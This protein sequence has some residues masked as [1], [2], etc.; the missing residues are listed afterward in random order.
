MATG[1]RSPITVVSARP[2]GASSVAAAVAAVLSRFGRTLLVDLNLDRPEQ[3]ALLDLDESPNVFHLAY[4]S[5][6]GPA[7]PAELEDHLQ[8]RDG[9]AVLPG[10]ARADDAV[11]VTDV[12]VDGLVATATRSFE[13]VV[14]DGGRPRPVQPSSLAAGLILWAVAPSPLG[15]AAL[16][17]AVGLLEE[18]RCEWLP[19]SRVLFNRVSNSSLTGVDRFVEREHNLRPTGQI[20]LAADY[21]TGVELSHSLRALTVPMSEGD[22]YLKTYGK[23]ALAVRRA[24]ESVLESLTEARPA[25]MRRE[26]VEV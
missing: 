20:P 10:I 16:D 1:P 7:G 5:K 21:W 26:A 18:A 2:D 8:W 3:A 17:K 6:L 4:R 23:E 9:I 15:L 14:L 11:E 25:R 22:R 24:V 19:R 12:F 13:R